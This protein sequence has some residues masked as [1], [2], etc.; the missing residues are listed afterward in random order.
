M[1]RADK[2]NVTVAIN[3]SDYKNKMLEMLSDP[4][5]YIKVNKDPLKKHY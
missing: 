5:I 1:T 4:E 3:K 2:G